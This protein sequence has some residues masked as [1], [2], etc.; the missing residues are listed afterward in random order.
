VP[1]VWLGSHWS[2]RLPTGTLRTAL[3]VVLVGAG[4]GLLTKAGAEIPAPLVAAVPI[5]LAV[6]IATTE[7][8]RR[9]PRP[10]RGR[11]SA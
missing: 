5:A 9:Q 4:L 1:G 10:A 2:V 7:L 6:L 3:G 11:A 8:A